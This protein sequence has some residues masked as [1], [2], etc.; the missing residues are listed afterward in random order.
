M[1]EKDENVLVVACM[2][3]EGPFLLEW[4]SYYMSIGV[5]KFII[6]SN[7]CNDG[8]DHMLD[9]LDEMGVVRHLPNPIMIESFDKSIQN[10]ALKYA[11]LQ[12]E[13]READWVLIVDADEFLNI[14]VGD[15]DLASLFASLPEFDAI[16]FNQV[17]F[18]SAQVEVFQ[19]LPV[20][21]QF[22]YRF[23]FEADPRNFPMMYGIKTLS[24]NSD[25]LFSRFSNHLPRLKSKA[26][27]EV[28]WLD[29]AGRPMHPDFMEAQPRSYPVYMS[30]ATSDDGPLVKSR[31]MFDIT[32]PT[33][34]VGYVN[35]Y[36]LRSLESFVMQSLR[37]DAVSAEVRRDVNYWR[38][39]DRNQVHDDTIHKQSHRADI[40]Q[41][42]LMK[43]PVLARLH[44]QAVEHHRATFQKMA[45]NPAIQTLME[46]CRNATDLV[47]EDSGDGQGEDGS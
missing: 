10:V 2:K 30:R 17:V 15:N 25:A 44:R 34:A 27:S 22:N 9:R 13:F 35:H 46:D 5:A 11:A 42:A 14:R 21:R 40:W 41:Q 36:S 1:S 24:R 33:H 31:K 8:T 4:L 6:V 28:R 20:A 16:S 12:R 29:G 45:K 19:D 32:P 3:D 39:Y 26:V 23:Q 43:D 18:G 37:G 47:E 7:D 38:S